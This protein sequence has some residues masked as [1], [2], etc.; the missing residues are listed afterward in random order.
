MAQSGRM[1][2]DKIK[3]SFYEVLKLE[4]TNAQQTLSLE[5]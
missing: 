2:R 1:T 3:Y 5:P 4:K